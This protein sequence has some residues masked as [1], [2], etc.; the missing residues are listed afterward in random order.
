MCGI[1]GIFVEGDSTI[2]IN[3]SSM[4][5]NMAQYIKNR[6][7][8]NTNKWI[9]KEHNFAMVHTRLSIVGLGLNG[10]QPMA[11]NDGRYIICFNGE[12]YNFKILKEELN[13]FFKIKWKGIS[14]TEV[15]LEGISKFGFEKFVHKA[16]GMFAFALFDK[17]EKILRLVRDRIG[18]KPLYYGFVK[19]DNF[20]SF[21]FS[22]DIGSFTKINSA[23]LKL[24]QNAIS[25]FVN[26][27][28]INGTKTIYQGINKV[29]PGE[30]VEINLTIDF[31]D[32]N[33]KRLIY[34]RNQFINRKNLSV[35]NFEESKSEL[36]TLLIDSL[37]DQLYAERDMA[38]FF[39]GGIDSS[40]IAALTKKELGLNINCLTCGFNDSLDSKI[41][42][43]T[44][45]A[46]NICKDLDLPHI[47]RTITPNDFIETLPE[48]S[49]IFSEPFADISQIGSYLI[50]KK[51][52]EF[53]IVVALG[54]DGGDELFGGYERYISGN[55]LLYL[56]N[57][58]PNFFFKYINK[59]VSF[60]P[61]QLIFNLGYIAG[62]DNIN[63][64]IEKFTNEIDNIKDKESL[65]LS[66]LSKWDR[67][68]FNLLG[69]EQYNSFQ[70]QINIFKD[71]DKELIDIREYM[72]RM[73]LI[74]YLVDDVLVKT[75]RTSMSVGLEVR[76][77]F[78]NHNVV[79]YA[80][81][82]PVNSK[83]S[84]GKGKLH[85]R[86]ILG[87]YINIKLFDRPKKGFAIPIDNILRTTA[88]NW[89]KEM[90]DYLKH[91]NEFN[92]NNKV[93]DNIWDEHIKGYRN[94]GSSLWNLIMLSSWMQ[95]WR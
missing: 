84:S 5:D 27:G 88:K 85:L 45:F 47:V 59:I 18:E 80:N 64:K 56:K 92:I 69:L 32:L 58:F 46:K 38:I 17:K 28:W 51:A 57:Y 37:R 62:I 22:S 4:L 52:R 2:D 9:S 26:N 19:G 65:Y 78:L 6:G 87:E 49:R 71:I 73:D 94:H 8:D 82:I 35:I 44:S 14:D 54:G 7:P 79:N 50:A 24:N 83:F 21:A 89:S 29:N 86:S 93:L 39:S 1:A 63:Y 53:G 72:M 41:Y 11:S 68:T 16:E 95:I 55:R 31:K 66:C 34:W 20:K 42:D 67:D 91:T 76:S 40:L 90:I 10:N 43:E 33:I 70:D 12:I 48:M 3:F 81:S 60:L 36:K 30:Y 13:K 25:E 77:P 15:L 61:E 74:N 23:K 75:D